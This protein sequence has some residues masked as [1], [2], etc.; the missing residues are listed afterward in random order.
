MKKRKR[1]NI[2]F[3]LLFLISLTCIIAG[4]VISFSPTNY[5]FG[6]NIGVAGY[7]LFGF[8]GVC[9]VHYEEICEILKINGGKDGKVS[10]RSL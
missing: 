2:L 4:T 7:I 10:N 5:L 1:L 8:L 3:V 9:F 6:R